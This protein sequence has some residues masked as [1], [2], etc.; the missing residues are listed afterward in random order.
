MQNINLQA[1]PNEPIKKTLEILLWNKLPTLSF[2]FN[3]MYITD[4]NEKEKTFYL[5]AKDDSKDYIGK[6]QLSYT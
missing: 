1:L 6:I 5:V 2:D 4:L 3:Q